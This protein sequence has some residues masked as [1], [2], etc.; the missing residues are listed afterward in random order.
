MSFFDLF[1]GTKGKSPLK[2]YISQSTFNGLSFDL[3]NFNTDI[4]DSISKIVPHKSEES[5]VLISKNDEKGFVENFSHSVF[6]LYL[7]DDLED[8]FENVF[9][10]KNDLVSFKNALE[11]FD[12][13]NLEKE[14]YSILER[15]R[16]NGQDL[17]KKVAQSFIDKNQIGQSYKKRVYEDFWQARKYESHNDDHFSFLKKIKDTFI[18]DDLLDFELITY[19]DLLESKSE[20]I[21]LEWIREDLFLSYKVNKALNGKVWLKLFLIIEVVD[22]YYHINGESYKDVD[23]AMI[24]EEALDSLSSPVAIIADN[25]DLLLY[26]QA[27]TLLEALPSSCLKLKNGS[28]VKY[29]DIYYEVLIKTMRLSQNRSLYFFQ[30]I[31]EENQESGDKESELTAISSSE[32]GIISSSIAHELNNPLA[33]I[34]AAISLL[35]LEDWDEEGLVSIHDMKKSAKRCKDLVEIFLSF[36]NSRDRHK[37]S[38]SPKTGIHQ[39]LDLLRFRMIES[40]VRLKVSFNNSKKEFSKEI[41]LSLATMIFYMLLGDMMTAFN[42]SQIVTG[43]KEEQIDIVLKEGFDDIVLSVNSSIVL[44]KDVLDSK[45]MN[46]LLGVVGLRMTVGD[47]K[48]SLESSSMI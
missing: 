23:K 8:K 41:N 46:Y 13:I 25:G 4:V 48:I 14:R 33:G 15:S 34:L 24:W 11:V 17:Y 30:S 35:E 7:N 43:E 5:I 29:Q 40:G 21:S 32:L 18:S 10:I 45:L 26:N 22:R 19:Q 16:K 2:I 37:K 28:V 20:L 3:K 9:T 47:H 42:R 39:A 31:K 44:S 6:T 38:G 12:L 27:F 36:S 1:E